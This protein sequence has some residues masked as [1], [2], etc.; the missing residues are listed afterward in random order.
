[1][2]KI[3]SPIPFE[4]NLES[5]CK[6]C[7]MADLSINEETLY[8]DS[9]RHMMRMIRCSKHDLCSSLY[10]HIKKATEKEGD[11]EIQD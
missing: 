2:Y 7:Y 10:R 1:M 6:D 5:Y 9:K 4:V 3:D 11:D 8:I